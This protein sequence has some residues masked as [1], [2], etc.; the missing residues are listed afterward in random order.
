[1]DI[2]DLFKEEKAP[3][4]NR[5]T[6]DLIN[7]YSLKNSRV[8]TDMPEHGYDKLDVKIIQTCMKYLSDDAII[9]NGIYGKYTGYQ[10]QK[11]KNKKKLGDDMIVDEHTFAM[12][13]LELTKMYEQKT[14]KGRGSRNGG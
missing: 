9:P 1:M 4:L 2:S 12:L 13:R 14:S 3:E 11:F 8:E 10:V 5:I 7:G 6:L